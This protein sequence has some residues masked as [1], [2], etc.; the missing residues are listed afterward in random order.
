[1][2]LSQTCTTSTA[3][4]ATHLNM[5]ATGVP[6]SLSSSVVFLHFPVSSTISFKQEMDTPPSL[7]V[8]NICKHYLSYPPCS[9]SPGGGTLLQFS[10]VLT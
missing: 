9:L 10:I 8:V 1:M 2:S 6:W 4:I 5:P 7:L 3:C